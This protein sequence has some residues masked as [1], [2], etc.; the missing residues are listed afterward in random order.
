MEI[1]VASKDDLKSVARL[2]EMF[3]KEGCCN[4]I[5]AD[6]EEYFE[7]KCVWI[8]EEERQIVAYAYGNIEEEENR[9]SYAERGDKF[10]ELE[11]IYVLPQYRS[12]GIGQ[13]LF[14]EIE[15]FAMQKGAKTMR[16]NAVSKNYKSL[17]KFYI[18]MLGM[19][20]ISAYLVKLL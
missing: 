11:E 18:D 9:R 13:K 7:D 15:M 1:R 16:L 8:C 2:S 19:E 3:A 14:H 5:V 17:L 4:N 12:K 10:F 6:N 20:F